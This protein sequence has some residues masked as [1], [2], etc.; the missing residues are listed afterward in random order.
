MTEET[1]ITT[2]ELDAD[3][4]GSTSNANNTSFGAAGNNSNIVTFSS[5]EPE[6]ATETL[7]SKTTAAT[8][9]APE[10]TQKAA[11]LKEKAV[12]F[13]SSTFQ[14][15]T[16][17]IKSND[18]YDLPDDEETPPKRFHFKKDDK[19]FFR[20][21]WILSR[22]QDDQLMDYLKLE[23]QRNEL[24]QTAKETKEKRILKAFQTAV[25]AGAVI[26]VVY[27]LK[28]NPSILINILYISGILAALWFWNSSKDK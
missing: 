13:T 26:A 22:I 12:E 15:A 1:L 27:L 9:N 28:D 17:H 10:F 18:S 25:L 7:A 21:K 16:N 20:D 19:E 8:E 23:Q 2:P 4:A 5:N 6:A 24:Q 11:V 14:K 3:S